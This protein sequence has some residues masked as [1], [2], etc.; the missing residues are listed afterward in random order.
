MPAWV[1]LLVCAY[2]VVCAATLL[3]AD[4]RPARGAMPAPFTSAAI[5]LVFAAAWPLRMLRVIGRP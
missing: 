4:F 2:L 3:E 1:W 5:A